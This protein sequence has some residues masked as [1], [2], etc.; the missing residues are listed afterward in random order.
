MLADRGVV[1]ESVFRL[2]LLTY[3]CSLAAAG[4]MAWFH[5][6]K[7]QQKVVPAEVALL[8]MIVL[9]WIVMG[10]FIFLPA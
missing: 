6:E 10:V 1:P 4:V 9:V 5:G 3:F 7:G 2:A 8:S